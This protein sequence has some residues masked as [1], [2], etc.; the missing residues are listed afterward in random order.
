MSTKTL[1]KKIEECRKE[2]NDEECDI[3][4]LS[5]AQIKQEPVIKSIVSNIKSLDALKRLRLINKKWR[6]IIDQSCDHDINTKFLLKWIKG[7]KETGY[8]YLKPYVWYPESNNIKDLD[9]LEVFIQD[10]ATIPSLHCLKKL[11]VIEIISKN[12]RYDDTPIKLNKN[13]TNNKYA[14]NF[15]ISNSN[16]KRIG[17]EILQLKNLEQLVLTDNKNLKYITPRLAELRNLKRVVVDDKSIVPSL[18]PDVTVMNEKEFRKFYEGS[19]YES[20]DD[21][22]SESDED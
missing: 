5:L 12:Y 11:D 20:Y 7:I 4:F 8:E 16:I 17:D 21:E 2:L 19:D 22:G 6:N 9:G 1:A 3:L 14:A 18:P 13:I 15:N 10:V